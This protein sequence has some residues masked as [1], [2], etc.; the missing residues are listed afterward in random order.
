MSQLN[1]RIVWQTVR[2]NTR[3]VLHAISLPGCSA[4]PCWDANANSASRCA[5]RLGATKAMTLMPV[6]P[7][8]NGGS[9]VRPGWGF[10][11]VTA[12]RVRTEPQVGS[13]V[14]ACLSS[15]C[16]RAQGPRFRSR[17]PLVLEASRSK[18]LLALRARFRLC[19]SCRLCAF[20]I[21]NLSIAPV[22]T[23]F[24]SRSVRLHLVN[25]PRPAVPCASQSLSLLIRALPALPSPRSC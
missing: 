2:L 15:T 24:L 14:P 23:S 25:V 5:S 22:S 3:L 19:A 21:S 9:G 12:D 6:S 10:S 4:H 7:R 11:G 16:H 18:S 8:L 13:Y 17:L 20:S 1:K